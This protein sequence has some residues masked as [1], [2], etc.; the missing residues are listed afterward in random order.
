[1]DEDE[2]YKRARRRV[3]ELKGFYTHLIV[4]FVVNILLALINFIST[5][6]HLWFYWVT[7]G[8]GIGV[9]M[10]AVSVF[11]IAGAMGP[12][13]EEKKIKELM[14]KDKPSG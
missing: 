13:W 12:E 5:P 8:W 14:D 10:N 6:E 7:L 1:M 3:K 11:G 9:V 2:K 4:F